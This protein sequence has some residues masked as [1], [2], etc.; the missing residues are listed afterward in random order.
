MKFYMGYEINMRF[1]VIPKSPKVGKKVEKIGWAPLSKDCI[2]ITYKFGKISS[3]LTTF[4]GTHSN[5]LLN[6]F[7]CV[8]CFPACILLMQW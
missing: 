1:L 5:N 7:C 6:I 8:F 3:S 4:E 2:I